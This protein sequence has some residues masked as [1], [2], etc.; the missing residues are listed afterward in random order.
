[1]STA[2]L[3]GYDLIGAVAAGDIDGI[4]AALPRTTPLAVALAAVVVA[5][6]RSV[7]DLQRLLDLVTLAAQI[8]SIDIDDP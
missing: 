1:M 5:E 6:S 7:P 4:N 3:A 8:N 2:L